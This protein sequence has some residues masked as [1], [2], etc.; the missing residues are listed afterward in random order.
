MSIGERQYGI[1]IPMNQ[2]SAPDFEIAGVQFWAKYEFSKFAINGISIMEIDGKDNT[3]EIFVIKDLSPERGVVRVRDKITKEEVSDALFYQNGIYVKNP[4][5]KLNEWNSVGIMFSSSVNLN[6]YSGGINVLAGATFNNI[7]F[8]K[9]A[10]LGK[11]TSVSTRP[12]LRALRSEENPSQVLVW[13]EWYYLDPVARSTNNWK[14]VY[15]LSESSSYISTPI[16]IHKSY[17]G[18]N[19]S[20]IG[21]QNVFNLSNRGFLVINDVSW[22]TISQK[23][24]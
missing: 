18:T 6:E 11:L 1:K 12:W 10:G 20:V 17:M 2:S 4:I 13:N 8:Y 14:S 7:S 19:K 15:V 21:D 9:P 22:S 16:D 5:I 23:P 3:Y 24:V